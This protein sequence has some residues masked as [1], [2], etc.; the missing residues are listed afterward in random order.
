[1]SYSLAKRSSSCD[2]LSIHSLVHSWAKL[3]LHFDPQKETEVARAAFELVASGVHIP[4]ESRMRT[5]DWIFEQ[6]VMPH[7]D[8]IT[9]HMS[10]YAG[11][12]DM[13]VGSSNLGDVYSRHGRQ[14]KALE[15]YTRALTGYENAL[16]VDHPTTLSTVHQMALVFNTQ[17]QYEKA[18]EWYGRALAGEEKALGAD[19]PST[20]STVCGM[21]SVFGKQ[22][23]YDKALE[24]YGR[25]L[26]GEE[27]ALGADHPST[28]TTV[29]GMAAVFD[30]QGQY[31]KAL[32][33]YG[34]ALVGREKALGVNHPLTQNTIRSLID[35]H[36][37]TGQTEQARNL[38][39]RFRVP[40]SPSK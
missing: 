3:R 39:T 19:H 9:E 5:V 16:G 38:R 10:K 37:T 2:S 8:A 23:Q 32:E 20:L 13:Q 14:N 29:H 35:L 7:I 36:E 4:D 21:A 30:R 34:R 6:R 24:L 40:H 1:L 28:L 31:D 22:G 11:L 26:A 12:G 33:W 18:L 27:K 25:V 17:G 15:W